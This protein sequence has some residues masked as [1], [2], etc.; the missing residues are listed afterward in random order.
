MSLPGRVRPDDAQQL[1]EIVAEAAA[2]G[3]RLAL[4]GGGSHADFGAPVTAVTEVDLRAFS[5]IVDYDAPELVITAGAGTPLAAV[6]AQLREQGQV[7]AFEPF[8]VA[9]LYGREAGPATLGGIIATG[10]AGPRRL[11]R[12][13]VRDHL[14]GFE[15]VSGRGESFV[16]GGRVV[17]N[18]T[19]Y[20]LPKLL[21]G[22]RGRLAAL[23]QVTLK[24][25]PAARES[26]TVQVSGLAP[27]QAQQ[28]FGA[29]QGTY[30]A[31]AAA[32][33]LP[34][35]MA[36]PG[37]CCLLRFEGFPPSVQES[38]QLLHELVSGCAG[39]A[40]SEVAPDDAAW[41][42]VQVAAPL[43]EAA[44]LWKIFAPVS[45]AVSLV[46]DLENRG[47]RWL[48][49]WAGGLT[50]AAVDAP[51][52]ELRGIAARAGGHAVLVRAPGELRAVTAALPPQVPALRALEEKV[53]RA[54]DPAGVFETGRFLAE[55]HEN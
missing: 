40:C 20:D 23:T 47:A 54:F 48:W 21:C 45:A 31:L 42:Q 33:Y 6:Q 26:R 5:G 55:D 37:S 29:L 38:V 32:A 34:A 14:L 15:A 10:T 28:V 8:D 41:A 19:G 2:G 43:A 30:T 16:A 50:W 39:A 4:R 49:D 27:D 53:R 46:R 13:T 24:V 51:P 25:L 1:C 7:L 17:K 18:V 9:P 3:Q 11:V 44:V 35:G 52:R 12:G 22:S 36:G